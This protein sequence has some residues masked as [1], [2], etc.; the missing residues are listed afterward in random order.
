MTERVRWCGSGLLAAACVLGVCLAPALGEPYVSIQSVSEWEE[1]LQGIPPHVVGMTPPEWEEYWQQW[2]LYTQEG[3]RYPYTTFQPPELYVYGGGGGGGGYPEDSG[4]VMVWGVA[5]MPAGEYASAWQYNYLTDPDLSNAIITTSVYAPQWGPVGQITQISL[6]IKDAAGLVRSWYWNVGAGQTIPWDLL[7]PVTIDTSQT[8]LNATTPAADGYMNT[9][10]FT[11]TTAQFLVADE[12]A[13]WLGPDLPVPP[14][15]APTDGN[16]NLWHNIVVQ[17]KPQG[18]VKW[19]Q[20]PDPAH[21][22][23]VYYGWNEKSDWWNGPI[24]ADD[25]I[26]ST[27]DPVTDVHW[28]GSF[29]GWKRGEL[30]SQLPNHFHIQ[31]WDD[32]PAVPGDPNSFSHPGQVIHEVYAYQGSYQVAFVGWDF[33]PRTKQYEACFRFDYDLQPSE[34][35]YQTAGTTIYWVSIAACEG[36]TGQLPYP[37]GWK[38]RPRDPL[39]PA[40]DDAVVVTDPVQPTWY[41]LYGG[42]YPIYWPTRDQSWDM[43]FELTTN[44]TETKFWGQTPDLST[45]GIDVNATRTPSTPVQQYT[46]ADDFQCTQTGPITQIVVYGSWWHDLVPNHSQVSFTLSLHSDVL[47]P[48]FSHPGPYLWYRTFSPGQYTYEQYAPGL[49][50]GWLNPPSAY[51]QN[52][53]HACWRYTF[54]LNPGEFTQQGTPDNPVI[55]W[56]DVHAT[57][58]S[59]AF[60]G[61]K[62]SLDHWNDDAV[63]AYG[64]E[65]IPQASWSALKYPTG[66][67]LAGQSIDLAFQIYGTST[68]QSTKWTQPP[69]PYRPPDAYN[70]WDQYSVYGSQLAA[71]DWFC[72]TDDPVTDIHWWGS[73]IGWYYPMQ[74]PLPE[75]FDIT[76]W[77]DVP[78]DPADPNSFSHPGKVLWQTRCTNYQWGF[79]GWDFDPRTIDGTDMPPE[80]TFE[81]VQYL[82]ESQ[83][84]WQEPGPHVYWVSISAVYPA[85]QIVDYPFGW[86]TLP[87]NPDSAAPDDAVWIGDPVWP[88]VGSV[89]GWGGPLFYPFPENSWDLAF[90]LTTKAQPATGACCRSNGWCII[91]TAADCAAAGG[92]YYGDGTTCEEVACPQPGACC[93]TDGTCYMSTVIAPGDCAAGDTYLGDDTTCDPNPCPPPTGA[94]CVGPVCMPDVTQEYCEQTLGGQYMGDDTTCDPNPCPQPVRDVVVCEPQGVVNNPFHPPT[95]W[96]DVTP[97]GGFGR[98]DFHVRVFD[99]NPGNYTNIVSPP[100]WQFSVHPGAIIGEYWASWWDP[101]CDNAIYNTFRFQFDNPG[102]STWGDWTTTISGTDDPYNQIVDQSGNHSGEP[103]GYGYRVHVPLP[104]PEYEK[105]SQPPTMN[106]MYPGYYYG[107]NELSIYHGPRIVADDWRCVDRRAISDIHWWGS[108][109]GWLEPMPPPDAPLAFHIGLWTDVPDG[110]TNPWS[111]PGRMFREWFVR[112]PD[113][114]ERW[115]G[116]DFHPEH[117]FETCFQYDFY[118]PRDEWFVQKPHTLNVY[119]LSISALYGNPCNADF[120]GDGDVDQADANTFNACLMAPGP[121]CW[122]A[123]LNWDGLVDSGDQPIFDCQLL[124]GWPDPACCVQQPVSPEYPWGWKTRRPEWNDDAVRILAPLPP[125]MQWPFEAGEPIRNLEGSWDMAFVLT[126]PEPT[127]PPC[128]GDCDCSA[129]INFDDINPFVAALAGGQAGWRAYIIQSQGFP[130]PCSFWNCDANSDGTV[131]FDDI[132]PFVEKLVTA[133]PCP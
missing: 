56:L 36:G 33:D 124:A 98:C 35:F 69:V 44:T 74:P 57:T 29:L 16:W 121:D 47:G 133:P 53:D 49:N 91:E 54:N 104:P 39:S 92:V 20:P 87:R 67:P 115:V 66:H 27:P 122:R 79:A 26:C 94:C 96:Y 11:L 108:Y 130:P 106:P 68:Q 103:D 117:G 81:F 42:G 131:D 97:G 58:P 32:V 59:T 37:W 9:P 95:Y 70:G 63:W 31:I 23:N 28:W 77:D 4:L 18:V 93:R 61:W 102:A 62:T 64:V 105:W 125:R 40:P 132:N 34:Y 73:F 101:D 22:Q 72:A 107:W 71:D 76:I 45:T 123:D 113:F 99:P 78:A 80:A 41:S 112:R 86:K 30:P 38:T 82:D 24:V 5:G 6:G 119:W 8:G 50:E 14:P 19:S 43:A 25:W 51:E 114:S 75:A 110:P 7:T 15:G 21:P 13:T 55:Y 52:A 89:W 46:L 65:P 88:V 116:M 12:N 48:P 3:E 127:P 10:G 111:H 90:E 84:F 1:A 83:W 126:A 128:Y 129:F 100:T 109:V 85:G 118:L 120:D 60:F 17:P 2:Q